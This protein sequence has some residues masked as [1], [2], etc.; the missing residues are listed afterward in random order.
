MGTELEL[1]E[2][3]AL[4]IS[5]AVIDPSSQ[6]IDDIKEVYNEIFGENVDSSE[7]DTALHELYWQ[8]QADQYDEYQA[9]GEIEYLR[10]LYG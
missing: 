9:N 7:I 2:K 6:S 1:K 8:E 4:L 5:K 10:K 3:L